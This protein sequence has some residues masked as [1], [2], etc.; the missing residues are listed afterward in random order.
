[1]K[2]ETMKELT[3]TIHDSE[4]TRRCVQTFTYGIRRVTKDYHGESW[5]SWLIIPREALV[6]GIR[7]RRAAGAQYHDCEWWTLI[8]GLERW[9]APAGYGGPGRAFAREPHPMRY[10]RRFMVISQSGGLD[11]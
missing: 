8:P 9:I 7:R 11:I 5:H 3:K 6:A 4:G 1:M 2:G 10:S